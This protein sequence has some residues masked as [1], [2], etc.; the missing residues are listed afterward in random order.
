[1][2]KVEDL[3]PH[4]KPMIVLDKVESC[5]FEQAKIVVSFTIRKEDVFFDESLNGVASYCALEYMAQA[6]GCFAGLFGKSQ[7]ANYKQDLG[8]V[9]GSRNMELNISTFEN[10]RTYKV[11]AS[12]VFFDDELASFS[13]TILDENSNVCA[14]ASINVFKP[15]NPLKFLNKINK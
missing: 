12:K 3:L 15:N 10:G 1:M 14:S 11:E 13:C 7:D 5:D 6:I 9:L 8:F 2:Y 4:R